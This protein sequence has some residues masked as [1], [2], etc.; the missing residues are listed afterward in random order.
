MQSKYGKD[1]ELDY[2]QMW[3]GTRLMSYT[4]NTMDAT[5]NQ[6]AGQEGPKMHHM[7]EKA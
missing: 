5:I 3:E 2:V 1:N 7:N 4:Q 6:D